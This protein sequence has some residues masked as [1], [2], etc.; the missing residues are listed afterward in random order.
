MTPQE[1]AAL[2][3]NEVTTFLYNTFGETKT[4]G[5]QFSD[6]ASRKQKSGES[7]LSFS[8]EIKK[9]GFI[10]MGN[11]LNSG[12]LNAIFVDGIRDLEV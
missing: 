5:Q 9:L 2:T 3:W 12:Q 10:A 6:F 4:K 7:L 11:Q 1:Q 8:N